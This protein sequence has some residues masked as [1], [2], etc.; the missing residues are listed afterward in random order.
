MESVSL[1]ESGYS[2]GS[3][4]TSQTSATSGQFRLDIQALRALAVLLVVVFHY[5][6]TVVPGGYIGVDVFFVVS[7]YLITGHLL[8]EVDRDG[9]VSLGRF[10]A[11]RV[12]RLLPASLTTLAIV[13]MATMVFVPETL[14]RR[15]LRDINASTLYVVNWALA[16]DAVDYFASENDPSPVQHFWSLSTEEQFYVFWP[17]LFAAAGWVAVKR[18]CSTRSAI[19]VCL[20]VA[21]AASFIVSVWATRVDQARAYFVSPTRAW[22]F[23]VGA[24]LVFLPSVTGQRFGRLRSPAAWLAVI[25]VVSSARL[26]DERT[27]FPGWIAAFPVIATALFIVAHPIDPTLSPMIIGRWR[28]AQF[29]GEVSYSWYLWHWPVLIL[30][31][32]VFDRQVDLAGKV[33][34]VG[35]SL[36]LATASLRFVETPFRTGARVN[37]WSTIR[38]L[39]AGLLGMALVVGIS[40]VGNRR[41]D[42]LE[43][44]LRAEAAP[45]S[46]GVCFGAEALDPVQ[47]CTISATVSLTPAPLIAS[48]DAPVPRCMV[49][50]DDSDAAT[51][52][53]GSAIDDADATVLVLGD[54]HAQHWR[55]AIDAIA[56]RRNWHVVVMLKGSCSFNA[57]RRFT[58]EINADSCDAWNENVLHEISKRPEISIVFVSASALNSYAE[59]PDDSL[60]VGAAG[61]LE[62][63]ASLPD[64][65]L[66]T[67]VI[68][69]IPRPNA[70]NVECLQD[71]IAASGVI[72]NASCARLRADAILPDAIDVATRD[73]P[74]RVSRVDL[75]DYFCDERRCFAAIGGVT[76]YRDEHHMTAT[77][78]RTLAPYLAERLSPILS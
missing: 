17:V 36:A 43:Q 59:D 9:S 68:L 73:A 11:R 75:N 76:V 6:P 21:T 49:D 50:R 51:C 26:M 32:F 14:W 78:S 25:V 77:F 7:G 66:Q 37:S 69:D 34:L 53:L 20:L 38:V 40:T 47:T 3:A 39:G 24:L 63:W 44:Q 74:E 58:D 28:A 67:I 33:A 57:A 31:P 65:V 1:R 30:A 15:F 61:Y 27:A 23:G 46:A 29:L 70:D 54:S 42:S 72:D 13:A 10:W 45:P 18:R 35:A 48:D 19:F 41:I 52:E 64:T 5:W 16:S 62:A 55:S 22:E 2:T 12:R 60:R 8:R 4:V 71:L 56:A